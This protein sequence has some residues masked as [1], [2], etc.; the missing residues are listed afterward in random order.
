MKR[1][2]KE[3][4]SVVILVTANGVSNIGDFVYLVALNLYVLNTTNSAFAVASIWGVPL[5]E[6]LLIGS[7]VGSITDRLP[8]RSTLI[9][10]EISRTI[11]VFLLP[12]VPIYWI[13]PLLFLLGLGSTIFSRCSLLLV[14]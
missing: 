14:Y 5:A 6:Q 2:D 11:I 8:L 10:V 1:V 13:Y 7:W 4:L 3:W 12:L 9:A